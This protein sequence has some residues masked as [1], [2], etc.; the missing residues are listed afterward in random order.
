M[1]KMT[2]EAAG[3]IQS[4]ADRTNTNEGFKERAQRAAENNDEST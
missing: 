4:A 1:G 2:K 3:R